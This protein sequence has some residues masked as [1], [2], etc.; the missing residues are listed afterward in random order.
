VTQVIAAIVFALS[1]A[2]GAHSATAHGAASHGFA[3]AVATPAPSDIPGGPGG[4][5]TTN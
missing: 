5:S 1:I 4:K 2:M 3:A